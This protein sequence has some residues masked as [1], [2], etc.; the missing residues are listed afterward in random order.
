MKEAEA[1]A[2]EKDAARS[3][4]DQAIADIGNI[5]AQGYGL[6][7]RLMQGYYGLKAQAATGDYNV[8]WDKDGQFTESRRR[9]ANVPLNTPLQSLPSGSEQYSMGNFEANVPQL[10]APNNMYN[11]MGNP[12]NTSNVSY[13]PSTIADV[14]QFLLNQFEWP[15]PNDP[16]GKY[17]QQFRDYMPQST[18]IGNKFKP[19]YQQTISPVTAPEPQLQLDNTDW[20]MPTKINVPDNTLPQVSSYISQQEAKQYDERGKNAFPRKYEYWKYQMPVVDAEYE[21]KACGG[22]LCKGGYIKK[23]GKK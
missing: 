19:H 22:K 20:Y 5:S 13:N 8:S 17:N 7:S 16:M 10:P 2:M 3:I 6:K 21:D 23:K 1:N 15:Y 11:G 14:N 12:N 4:R 9:D 18:L